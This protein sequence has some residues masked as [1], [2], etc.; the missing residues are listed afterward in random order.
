M[1]VANWGN[2]DWKRKP[3]LVDVCKLKYEIKFILNAALEPRVLYVTG[4]ESL[5]NLWW[6]FFTKC[7]TGM[8]QCKGMFLM[9]PEE[10]RG[11]G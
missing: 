2:N 6:R 9:L 5:E 10:G 8:R 1:E 7:K 3:E 4:K 11:L